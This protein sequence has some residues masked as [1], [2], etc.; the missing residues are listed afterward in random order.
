MIEE[1]KIENLN[2]ELFEIKKINQDDIKLASFS[3]YLQNH[4]KKGYQ[5]Y[6]KDALSFVDRGFKKRVSKR[7]HYK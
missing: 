6:K 1:I 2:K 7:T 3:H 4:K 5:S